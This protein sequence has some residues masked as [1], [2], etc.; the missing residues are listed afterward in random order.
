MKINLLLN[1]ITSSCVDNNLT[2]F[3]LFPSN[4]ETYLFTIIIHNIT[5]GLINNSI[6]LF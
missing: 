5:V 6:N 2:P 4:K 3:V 1:Y